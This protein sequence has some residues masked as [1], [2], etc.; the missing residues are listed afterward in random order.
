ADEQTHALITALEGLP[1]A[2]FVIDTTLRLLLHNRHARQLVDRGSMV[3][4]VGRI[5]APTED[6]TTR[7]HA[8]VIDVAAGDP[9]A[10]AA[11]AHE[12]LTLTRPSGSPISV[13]ALLMRATPAREASLPGIVA[14]FVRDPD[15]RRGLDEDTLRQVCGLTETEA[16]LAALVVN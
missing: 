11:S 14:L 10:E 1:L 7:L 5:E 6:G 3:V 8:F 12:S 9:L 4:K 15:L 2:L 16:R 13:Q